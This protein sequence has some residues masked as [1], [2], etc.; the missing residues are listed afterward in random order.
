MHDAQSHQRRKTSGNRTPQAR[1][2]HQRNSGSRTADTAKLF[3]KP[4]EQQCA[5]ELSNVTCADEQAAFGR[6]DVPQ[7]D[8]NRQRECQRQRVK[9]VEEGCSAYNDASLRVP[10]GERRIFQTCEQLGCIN[11]MTAEA[12]F[13]HCEIQR[14]RL[15]P[16]ARRRF[17]PPYRLRAGGYRIRRSA[18]AADRVRVGAAGHGVT[19][20][21]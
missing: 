17:V 4:T 14:V 11:S 21:A 5:A 19:P 15:M 1:H 10:S 20:G 12:R 16:E 2:R 8:E 3:G 13:K 7:T 18:A 6:G 9:G